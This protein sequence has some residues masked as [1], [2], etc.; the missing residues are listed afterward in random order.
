MKF[1]DYSHQHGK[2]LLEVLHPQIIQEVQTILSNLKPFSHGAKKHVTVKRYVTDAF[3]AHGSE[4]EGR[5]DFRTDKKDHFSTEV[6]L[7]GENND[8]RR[9]CRNQP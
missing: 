8:Y 1:N 6:M 4:R 3:V 9:C 5:A 2:D 7:K